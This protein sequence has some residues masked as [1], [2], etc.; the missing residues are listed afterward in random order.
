MA[1][2]PISANREL[3]RRRISRVTRGL[4][5]ASAVATAV[6]GVAAAHSGK[7]SSGGSSG[8]VQED[9]GVLSSGDDFSA[10]SSALGPSQSAPTPSFGSPVT[11]SGGS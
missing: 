7:V 1:A 3:Q 2:T 5:V 10:S 6:F 9:D 8:A 4:A 11:S